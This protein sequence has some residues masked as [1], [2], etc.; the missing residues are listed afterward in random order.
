[1]NT[2]NIYFIR[3]GEGYHNLKTNGNNNWNLEYPR[4]TLKGIKQ[5]L[6]IKKLNICTDIVLV[7]PLRRTL[8]TANYIFDKNN[9]I[10]AIDEIREFLYNPC[11]KKE[12]VDVISKCF[13]NVDFSNINDNSDNFN[14][15]ESEYDISLRIDK[16]YSYLKTLNYKNITVVTH[17]VFLE[18]FI[19]KYGKQLN[20][21]N[22][23]F[24]KNCE[25]RHG[26]LNN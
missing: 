4:L 7:S 3:H 15:I 9:K 14:K 10:V 8:E 18:R 1:M 24:F 11:D 13:K 19:N 17:G 22:N 21:E 20:I 23:S 12:H 6:D 25:I 16:F 2:I 5:C 26:K